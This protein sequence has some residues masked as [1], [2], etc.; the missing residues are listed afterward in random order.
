MSVYQKW[1]TLRPGKALNRQSTPDFVDE[2]NKF[3]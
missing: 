1:S 3:T 2:E